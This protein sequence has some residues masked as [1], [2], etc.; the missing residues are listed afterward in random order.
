[1][2][3]HLPHDKK[4]KKIFCGG[5]IFTTKMNI[6]SIFYKKIKKIFCGAFIF[7]TKM[8][9]LSISSLQS[10]KS[11]NVI[12]FLQKNLTDILRS[13]TLVFTICLE[14]ILISAVGDLHGPIL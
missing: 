3:Y 6:L 2:Y 4:I 11:K 1:M 9:I 8:N 12:H 14:I 13:V 7:T 10:E 5:F